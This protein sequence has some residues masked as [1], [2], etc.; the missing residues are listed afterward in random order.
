MPRWL[1]ARPYLHAGALG[2]INLHRR[3]RAVLPGL[4]VVVLAAGAGLTLPAVG[5]VLEFL[6]QSPAIPFVLVGA[7]TMVLTA[8][9][10]AGIYQ[11]LLTSWLAPL[12]APTSIAE[13]MI[14]PALLQ[15][16]LWTAAWGI[17]YLAG[18]LSS[19][20]ARPLAI[21]VAVAWFAGS[22]AG[23]LASQEKSAG[24]P[25]FHYVTI[26][27]PRP[28][29]KTAPRLS[30][31]SYWAAGQARVA[32]KPQTTAKALIFVLLALPLGTPGEKVIAI[33]G[34]TLV[35][36]YLVALA[37]SAAR[38]AV[39]AARWLSVT[40]VRYVEFTWALGHR[41]LGAQLWTCAWVVVFALMLSVP[42][43]WRVGKTLTAC[44][45]LTGL[46]IAVACWLAMRAMGMRPGS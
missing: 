43:A 33:A 35:V 36:W 17:P 30:P 32:A 42:M 39:S 28:D 46:D 7:V 23:W 11:G 31:L 3:N 15:L 38:V 26:R 25:D 20:G 13:R 9:R 14:L 4:L 34:G 45:L 12:A 18:S 22:V 6:G 41:V 16:L 2:W 44:A 5:V 19:V 29:W 40:T 1:L 27:K 37:V 8:R 24:A 21:A 10:K